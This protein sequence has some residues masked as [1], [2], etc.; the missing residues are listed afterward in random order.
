M[1]YE[2]AG[3][4]RIRAQDLEFS[5]VPTGFDGKVSYTIWSDSDRWNTWNRWLQSQDRN[6]DDHALIQAFQN[7]LQFSPYVIELKA[8]WPIEKYREGQIVC[9]GDQINVNPK[10]AICISLAQNSATYEMMGHTHR[11]NDEQWQEF[12]DV[13]LK[14]GEQE[15]ADSFINALPDPLTKG[16]GANLT[17]FQ[18]LGCSSE[19]DL[20][21]NQGTMTCLGWQ[22]NEIPS[23]GAIPK[24]PRF[25]SG[26]VAHFA[27]V[28]KTA[29]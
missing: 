16:V 13:S 4:P 28:D 21:L 27:Y 29:T 12:K 23:L 1:L 7:S 10:G 26:N 25:Q 3:A 15:N 2:P 6:T 5:Q 20:D 11:L 19:I 24:Y 18:I 8:T 14:E 22:P 17:Y 9:I